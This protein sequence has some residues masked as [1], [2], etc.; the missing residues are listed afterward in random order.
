MTFRDITPWQRNR[1]QKSELSPF[2]SLQNEMNRLFSDVFSG[3]SLEPLSKS[4]IAAFSPSI[5][6]TE[7]EDKLIVKAE[8]PGMDEKDID[9]TL[10]SDHLVIK[11]EK[12]E[13]HE[14]VGEN[15]RRYVERSYGSFQ[16]AIPL[17]LEID[18]DKVEATFKKGVLT[19]VLPKTADTKSSARKVSVRGE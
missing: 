18:E 15:D 14:E 17:S 10:L 3:M 19:V 12:R 13:E 9:L 7:K 16:R 6:V 11:G 2:Y 1:G 4:G 8:L 5:D